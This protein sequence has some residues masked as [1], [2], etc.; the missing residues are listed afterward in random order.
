M[1]TVY[2]IRAAFSITIGGKLSIW[3]WGDPAIPCGIDT[4]HYRSYYKIE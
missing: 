2:A 3:H 4:L 1:I